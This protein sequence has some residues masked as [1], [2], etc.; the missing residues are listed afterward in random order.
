MVKALAL[1]T[2]L[3][4]LM[5]TCALNN[6]LAQTVSNGN[7]DD[8][9]PSTRA[10][11]MPFRG[12][13]VKVDIERKTIALAGRERDRVFHITDQTRIRKDGEPANLAD[14]KVGDTVGGL[15]RA[16]DVPDRWNVVTLNVGGK[17]DEPASKEVPQHENAR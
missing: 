17:P 13:I 11:Q 7:A 10:K 1:T 4:A 9:K 6:T 15:A 3:S 14:V 12:T 5:L 2:A 16:A 8:P